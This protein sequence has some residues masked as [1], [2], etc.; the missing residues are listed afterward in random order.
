MP[1]IHSNMVFTIPHKISNGSNKEYNKSTSG[2][3]QNQYV[4]YTNIIGQ[5]C[6]IESGIIE[7]NE[8]IPIYTY[9]MN[10]AIITDNRGKHPNIDTSN[11]IRSGG[12]NF[13]DFPKNCTWIRDTSQTTSN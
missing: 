12:L 6:I 13:L 11:L 2:N 9:N 3:N 8:H 10:G 5:N 7:G 1:S 4:V